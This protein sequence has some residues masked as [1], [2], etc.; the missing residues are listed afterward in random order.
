MIY[1]KAWAAIAGLLTTLI[2]IALILCRFTSEESDDSLRG[3]VELPP[4]HLSHQAAAAHS[5]AGQPSSQSR[6]FEASDADLHP[7]KQED[8]PEIL[9]ALPVALQQEQPWRFL[10]PE[11]VVAVKAVQ[12]EFQK[13][14]QTAGS[15]SS[16]LYLERWL[17]EQEL[18]DQKLMAYLGPDD[19][20]KLHQPGQ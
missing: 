19:F 20:N 18:A 6:Y 16:A 9:A 5:S 7:S 1:S 4:N 17:K 2:L 10:K 13:A 15:P 14:M 12:K 3:K 8:E 11:Q